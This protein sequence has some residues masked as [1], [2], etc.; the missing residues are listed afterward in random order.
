MLGSQIASIFRAACLVVRSRPCIFFQVH[1]CVVEHGR[2]PSRLLL[3]ESAAVTSHP[4]SRT[5][6]LCPMLR[7]NVPY[8]RM[9]AAGDDEASKK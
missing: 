5:F 7:R 4:D 6:Q 2:D 1:L 9:T 8:P 3:C